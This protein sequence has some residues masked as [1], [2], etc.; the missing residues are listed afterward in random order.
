MPACTQTFANATPSAWGAVIIQIGCKFFY[1]D[2]H[3]V[4]IR[5]WSTT[6]NTHISSGAQPD[7]IDSDDPNA[8][9][10]QV[11]IG[12]TVSIP[13]QADQSFVQ[14]APG[15][16]QDCQLGCTWTLGQQAKSLGG[17]K[18]DLKK[19]ID[20]YRA[21]P[22]SRNVDVILTGAPSSKQK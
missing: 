8:C 20:G 14:S 22:S 9:V 6:K 16:A 12:M 1:Q 7:T 13:G 17:N 2:V 3:G 5:E 18:A 19:E 15:D 10:Q 11:A 4:V 21:D